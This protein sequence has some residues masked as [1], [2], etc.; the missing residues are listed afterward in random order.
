LA[1]IVV[2]EC[3]V[4]ALL[5][6]SFLTQFNLYVVLRGVAVTLLVAF[7][8]LVVLA[9]GQLNLSVGAIGGLVAVCTGGLME[10]WGMPTLPAVVLG[11]LLGTAAGFINGAL[12]ARTGIN[13]FVITLATASAFTGITIGLN[14]A[15]PFYDLPARYVAFGQAQLGPIPA[16][17]FVTLLVVLGLAF[18]FGRVVMGRQILAVGG[19]ARAAALSGIPVDRVVIAAHALSGFLAAVAAILLMA[20]LGSAQPSIGSDWLLPS[21]AIPIVGGVALAGGGAP[22]LTTVLAAF[23]IALIDNGLV[24]T[25]ADPYWIQ[26]LLG[27]IILG[28]VGLNRLRT[29]AESRD[30]R[31]LGVAG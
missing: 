14:N 15:E 8:Q 19:N 27:A 26:F 17:G 2:L 16:I 12:T 18:F 23:L 21:F 30:A 13:G 20:R 31:R 28:A 25:K 1:G 3:A 4:L 24:L 9:I 22:V 7:A 6:P 5:E 11:L 10:V 29:V